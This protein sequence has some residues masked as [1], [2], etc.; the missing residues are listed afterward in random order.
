MRCA[1]PSYAPSPRMT[2]NGWCGDI[3]SLSRGVQTRPVSTGILSHQWSGGTAQDRLFEVGAFAVVLARALGDKPLQTRVEPE[4][5]IRRARSS[6]PHAGD[7]RR[8]HP[9]RGRWQLLTVAND[10]EL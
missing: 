4:P 8:R 7:R 9:A 2:Q 3:P 6:A 1:R 10:W 5:S